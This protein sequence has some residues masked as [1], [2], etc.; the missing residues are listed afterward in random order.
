M[1]FLKVKRFSSLGDS[2]HIYINIDNIIFIEPVSNTE[3]LIRISFI[4]D[5]ILTIESSFYDMMETIK[6]LGNQSTT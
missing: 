5:T 1:K 2:Y 4:G 6:K 3:N